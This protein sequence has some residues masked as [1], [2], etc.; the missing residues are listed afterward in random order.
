MGVTNNV[1]PSVTSVKNTSPPPPPKT[2]HHHRLQL[3]VMHLI[4][5]LLLTAGLT[6]FTQSFFL[7]RTSFDH[8]SSCHDGSAVNLLQ[9]ALG[10]KEEDVEFLRRGGFLS[11]HYLGSYNGNNN[12]NNHH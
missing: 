6:I 7:S 12:N 3:L 8:R 9:S 10:L 1:T 4:P 2:I 11:D 5:P